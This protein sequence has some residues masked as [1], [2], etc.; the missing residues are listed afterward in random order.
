MYGLPF[1][2]ADRNAM[3]FS[4]FSLQDAPFTLGAES[5]VPI[6]YNLDSGSTGSCPKSSRLLY[7]KCP[8]HVM[9]FVVSHAYSPISPDDDTYKLKAIRQVS[10]KNGTIQFLHIRRIH[11]LDIC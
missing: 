6:C 8:T 10:G 2:D 7:R 4:D 11:F 5:L 3:I 1:E 9:T